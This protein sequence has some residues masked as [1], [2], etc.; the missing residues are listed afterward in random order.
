VAATVSARLCGQGKAKNH[1]RAE[2]RAQISND[3]QEPTILL[4]RMVMRRKRK[5][6][7]CDVLRQQD[8]ASRMLIRA[9]VTRLLRLTLPM[10]KARGV[11]SERPSMH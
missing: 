7:R 11:S 2:R 1:W 8:S 3:E 5:A 6:R 10:A 9:D 4:C